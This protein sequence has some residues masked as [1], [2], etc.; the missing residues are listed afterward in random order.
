MSKMVNFF[1]AIF[2]FQFFT[3]YSDQFMSNFHVCT[4]ASKKTEGFEQLMD[5]CKLYNIEIDVLGMDLPYNGNG[6]K[7]IYI[8]E[9]L[10]TLSDND[11]IMFVDAYDTLILANK[12][13]ILDKFLE[14]NVTCIFSAETNL[15]PHKELAS[16]FPISPTKFKYLNSGSFIGYVKY[17]KYLLEQISPI[18]Y[19]SDQGQLITY[20]VDHQDEIQLDFFCEFFFPLTY[21]EKNELVI[22]VEDKV[23]KCLLTETTPF[24]IHGN[25]HGKPMYQKIYNKL[26]GEKKSKK[27]TKK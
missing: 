9:Y 27:P 17:L 3:I 15:W 12:E 1:I 2:L 16:R 11:I 5:S 6:Q 14:K 8:K 26:F 24:V 7:L 25:G 22:D 13:T 10:N 19:T 4:V 20:Y 23:V 21:I 18:Q